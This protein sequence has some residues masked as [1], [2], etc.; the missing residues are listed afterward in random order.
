MEK[1]PRFQFG[2]QAYLTWRS[3]EITLL[4]FDYSVYLGYVQITVLGFW[5]SFW[6]KE[7]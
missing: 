2:K 1:Q 7:V 6:W 3:S 4:H 5:V